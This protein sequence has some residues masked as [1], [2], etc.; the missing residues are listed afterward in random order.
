MNRSTPGLPVHHQL[1]EFT[2]THKFAVSFIEKPVGVFIKEKPKILTI[3]IIH[4]K[5]GIIT[6]SIYI[7]MVK[8]RYYEQFILIDLVNNEK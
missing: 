7:K 6:H 3:K 1:P 2:Q 4:A 8:N 5:G